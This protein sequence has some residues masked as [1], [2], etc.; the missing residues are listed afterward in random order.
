MILDPRRQHAEIEVWESDHPRQND[1]V[2]SGWTLLRYTRRM[3][4]R[5]PER[6]VREVRWALA[7]WEGTPAAERGRGGQRGT[8]SHDDTS[9]T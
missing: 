4:L 1:V 6:I 7:A 3:Y 8:T 9:G 5:E 2:L